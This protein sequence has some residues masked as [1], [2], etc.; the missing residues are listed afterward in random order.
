[1]CYFPFEILI[2]KYCS[3][4][5]S[6]HVIWSVWQDVTCSECDMLG[7]WHIE[8]VECGM[9]GMWD[10]QD[11]GCSRCGMLG[12]WDVQ[13]MGCWGCGM[14]EMRND[15]DVACSGC[16]MSG[17]WDVQDVGC[18][19]CG[20]WDVWDEECSGC[21]MFWMWDVRDVEDVG[22]LG[23]GIFG[24]WDVGYLP[25]CWMLT[26]KMP[27]RLNLLEWHHFGSVHHA[28]QL[29]K[30]FCLGYA[31][32]SSECETFPSLTHSHWTFVF[33]SIWFRLLWNKWPG[34]KQL[35]SASMIWRF[36]KLSP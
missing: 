14:F 32:T 7:K 30:T 5:R 26:Y 16:G 25:G 1:M 9:Y 18:S 21:G 28:I 8:N 15:R 36:S 10:V 24:M 35:M 3:L 19:G 34:Q 33:L 22:C 20:M 27:C 11:V 17:M 23:C 29:P 12:M 13:D 31:W 4:F 6:I 2:L